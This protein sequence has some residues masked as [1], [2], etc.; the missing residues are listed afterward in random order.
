VGVN[1][2]LPAIIARGGQGVTGHKAV[3][4]EWFSQ[5]SDRLGRVRVC[6]GDWKRVCGPTPTVKQGLTAVFLDPP[7]ADTANRDPELYRCDSESVAHDVRDWAIEH[8]D[9]S[10]IRI[11][12]C[13]YEDEH[14]MPGAWTCIPW[15]NRKGYASQ[16]RCPGEHSINSHRERIWFSPHCLK[17]ALASI[18]T[19]QAKVV[20]H[21]G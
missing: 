2:S 17:P 14:S 6:C 19:E 3:L 9:D 12:L 20:A 21:V 5:L 10:R 7:Y 13:G 4:S 18:K 15:K 16:K 11:A 1:R 8:G